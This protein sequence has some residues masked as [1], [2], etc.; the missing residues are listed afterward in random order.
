M[1]RVR[2]PL[3]DDHGYLS[4]DGRP[5]YWIAADALFGRQSVLEVGPNG[6][7]GDIGF[8]L[9]NYN[10]YTQLT[11]RAQITYFQGFGAPLEF[12]IGGI[13]DDPPWQRP[14]F[15]AAVASDTFMHPDG[16]VTAMYEYTL[17][18]S[19]TFHG[20]GIIFTEYP[21]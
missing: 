17:D 13:P 2:R 11:G 4:H 16:W 10:G 7:P 21:A 15:T 19:P 6:L 12:G 8:A 9:R 3:H 1:V 20:F 18:S 5:P 14:D